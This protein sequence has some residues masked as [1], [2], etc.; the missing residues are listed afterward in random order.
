MMSFLKLSRKKRV[1][2]YKR[3]TSR[4][5]HRSI[6]PQRGRRSSNKKG[7]DEDVINIPPN[8]I[9]EKEVEESEPVLL[10]HRLWESTSQLSKH[11]GKGKEPIGFHSEES[12][13]EESLDHDDEEDMIWKAME[14]EINEVSPPPIDFDDEGLQEFLKSWNE[15]AKELDEEGISY[16]ETS[17]II[18]LR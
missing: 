14:P 13:E 8:E 18:P 16:P 2:Y 5:G 4:P 3:L 12:V 1:K 11:N 17:E 6:W 7:K 9:T 10:R 15:F